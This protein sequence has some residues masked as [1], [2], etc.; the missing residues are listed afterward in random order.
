MQALRTLSPNQRAWARFKRNRIGYGSLWIMVA[1]LVVS[2]LAELPSQAALHRAA[3]VGELFY[4]G[5]F[6]HYPRSATSLERLLADYFE[7]PVRVRQFHGQWWWLDQFEYGQFLGHDSRRAA[8]GERGVA[9]R[10]SNVH[11]CQEL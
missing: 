7:L 2:A 1:L 11:R 3:S 6:A 10:Q 5:H 8:F 9:R 4:A